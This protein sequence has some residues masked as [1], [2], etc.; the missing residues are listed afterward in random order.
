LGQRDTQLFAV[1]STYELAAKTRLDAG[2]DL[3]RDLAQAVIL[4]QQRKR[5]PARV[6]RAA[7]QLL[8]GAEESLFITGSRRQRVEPRLHDLAVHVSA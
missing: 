7:R 5:I 1:G 8:Y 2:E 6:G 4:V 3:T